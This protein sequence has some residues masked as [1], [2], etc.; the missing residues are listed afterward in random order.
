MQQHFKLTKS[1][2][3]DV[4]KDL[5]LEFSEMPPTPAERPYSEKR[6]D[7][8][9][10]A[11]VNGAAV[12]FHWARALCLEDNKVY[13]INGQHS[14]IMLAGL[15]GTMP[16]NLKAHVDDYEV[17]DKASLGFLFRQIDPRASARSISD[18]SAVYQGLQDDLAGV[19]KKSGRAAIE[20]IAWFLGRIVGDYI[21]SGDD[22]FTLFQQPKHHPFIHMIGRIFSE[23]T[24][25]FTKAVLGAMYG[26]WECAPEQAETFWSD[27]AHEGGGNEGTHPATVLD[28]WLLAAHEAKA[29][30]KPKE[31]EIYR[32]CALAWNAYRNHRNL[33]RIGRYD[34][35]KGAPDL[36]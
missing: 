12:S 31:R 17:P 32:A 23:K 21:P 16:E 35:K 1:E 3:L 11:V 4:T 14:S 24:P 13:R 22:K 10:D 34:P 9:K 36:E 7:Y 2:T 19:S 8:L 26:T 6:H 27:V 25:E 5:V 18:I 20:G 28:A 29:E 15:D 30:N 33:E